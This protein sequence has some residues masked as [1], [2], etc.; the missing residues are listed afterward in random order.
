MYITQI[1]S[2]PREGLDPLIIGLDSAGQI[3]FW[4]KKSIK[5]P[6]DEEGNTSEYIYGWV[7]QK[8]EINTY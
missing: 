6:M 2:C 8:D 7:L 4:E 5:I 1:S 3:Y